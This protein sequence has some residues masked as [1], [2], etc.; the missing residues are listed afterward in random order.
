MTHD[1]ERRCQ[2]RDTYRYEQDQRHYGSKSDLDA[3]LAAKAERVR[4]V[5]AGWKV[6]PADR[7]IIKQ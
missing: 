1:Q 4:K 3:I 7:P 2:E 5:Q 6:A